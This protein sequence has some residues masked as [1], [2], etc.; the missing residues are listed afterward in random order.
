[1]SRLGK[2]KKCTWPYFYRS[3]LMVLSHFSPLVSRS[4]TV[5]W[6]LQCREIGSLNTWENFSIRHLSFSRRP[7]YFHSPASIHTNHAFLTESGCFF[8]WVSDS[9][10]LLGLGNFQE[11]S[12]GQFQEQEL[13]L[14]SYVFQACSITSST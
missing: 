13:Y 14:I 8:F 10:N 12:I 6:V 2:N 1:M 11:K 4:L 7:G 5:C 9:R 3:L